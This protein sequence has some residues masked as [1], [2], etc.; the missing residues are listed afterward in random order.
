[1]KTWL[2][3][4]NILWNIKHIFWDIWHFSFF[5]WKLNGQQNSLVN[6]PKKK[7]FLSIYIYNFFSVTQKKES[8][9][10]LEWHEVLTLLFFWV[11]EWTTLLSLRCIEPWRTFSIQ[12]TKHLISQSLQMHTQCMY[13]Y[14]T[15]MQNMLS[16][17]EALKISPAVLGYTIFKISSFVS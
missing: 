14:F 12:S 4:I 15:Y 11:L 5:T 9:T 13:T 16:L 1:M 2:T 17:S 10:G 6:I 8:H 7:I 3:M